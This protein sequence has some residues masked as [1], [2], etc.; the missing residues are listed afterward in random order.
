MKPKREKTP[1]PAAKVKVIEER[2]TKPLSDVGWTALPN[3]FLLKQAALRLKPM[4]LNIILQIA[5]HWWEP[6]TVPFPKIKTIAGAMGVTERTVRKHISE[7]VEAGLLE[8]TERYY[9]Q[10]GQRSNAYTFNG[11]IERSKPL[12]EEILAEREK[13]KAADARITRQRKKPFQVVGP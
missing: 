2:W 8:R 4:H 13:K 12:A 1:A 10:G 11:L 9:A 3:V 6:G 7:M 5:K